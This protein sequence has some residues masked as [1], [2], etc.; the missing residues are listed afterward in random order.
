MSEKE[1]TLEERENVFNR[2]KKNEL[3]FREA[4]EKRAKEFLGKFG[5]YVYDQYEMNGGGFTWKDV[6]GEDFFN[7]SEE[8]NEI[9]RD[10]FIPIMESIEM[11][12]FGRIAE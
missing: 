10:Y 5:D 12:V 4:F 6:S 3:K 9:W 8:E 1:M 7:Y 2:F 11:K